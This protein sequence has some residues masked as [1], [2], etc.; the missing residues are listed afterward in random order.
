VQRILS[1]L[2]VWPGFNGDFGADVSVRGKWVEESILA[3][4]TVERYLVGVG[5]GARR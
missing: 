3:V 1:A 4:G 2:T 5:I